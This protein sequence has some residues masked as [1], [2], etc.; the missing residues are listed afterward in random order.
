MSELPEDHGIRAVIDDQALS[1]FIDYDRPRLSQLTASGKFEYFRRR[2]EF[3]VLEPLAVLLD[4]HD[5]TF[6]LI[7]DLEEEAVWRR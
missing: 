6:H 1:L 4:E 7:V 2:F 5:R 3:A